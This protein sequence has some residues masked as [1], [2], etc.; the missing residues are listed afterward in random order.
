MNL[1]ELD[2]IVLKGMRYNE[3]SK[4]ISLFTENSGKI[5]FIAKGVRSIKSGQ[6]GVFEDMNLIRISFYNKT[7]RSLQVINKSE[8]I[9]THNNIKCN[10]DKLEYAYRILEIMNN[11]TH[12]FDINPKVFKLLRNSL[13]YLN[14]NDFDGFNVYLYFQLNF[15]EISGIGLKSN[16]EFSQKNVNFYETFSYKIELNRY[17][18]LLNNNLLKILN[19]NIEDICLYKFSKNDCIK[20]IDLMD[21]YLFNNFDTKYFFNTKNIFKT[22][23]IN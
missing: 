15:A 20:F 10:L 13:S 1:T 16:L 23:N 12:N 3:T 2:A 22:I 21:N 9:D 8:S 11:L 5:N 6:C 18:E 7:N 19:S 4:I 14:G 17:G